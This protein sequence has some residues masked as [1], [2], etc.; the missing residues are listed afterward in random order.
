MAENDILVVV[1]YQN[2][3]V[4]GSLGF[5]AAKAIDDALSEKIKAHWEQDGTV[6]F[7]YDTHKWDYMDTVEGKNLPV[8]HCLHGMHGWQLYGKVAQVHDWGYEQR[9]KL[10]DIRK[11]TFGSLD[12]IGALQEI[13]KRS[14]C[15]ESDLR[16]TFTGVVTNI[17]VISNAVIA[18]A[19]VPEADIS[20]IRSLCAS[21]DPTLEQKAFDILENLHIKVM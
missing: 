16:V 10:Y 1:D 15:K 7:T 13:L 8:P 9:K 17:C 4:D 19:A 5:E 14:G 20:V 6:I 3:F 11:P 18:K 2:D 21:N 12:L